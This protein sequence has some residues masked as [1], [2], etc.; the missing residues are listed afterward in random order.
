M[1]CFKCNEIGHYA[2]NCP[3]KMAEEA[4]KANALNKGYE[5]HSKMGEN[6]SHN[7]HDKPNK[8]DFSL[9]QCFT[10]KE[11]GHYSWDC[12][13]KKKKSKMNIPN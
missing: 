10:C 2:D 1:L 8:K 3:E 9:V 13:E 7:L 11:M 4:A 6:S 12:P 5:N